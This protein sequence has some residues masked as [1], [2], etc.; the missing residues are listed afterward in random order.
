MTAITEALPQ[1]R[2]FLVSRC[3]IS[4]ESILVLVKRT[5]Y[6][7][8]KNKL[9][10]VACIISCISAEAEM[11]IPQHIYQHT[12]GRQDQRE[13]PCLMATAKALLSLQI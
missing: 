3:I 2:E 4:E 12:G 11:H 10:A 9:V 8:R 6:T 13:V 5:Q 1:L 7:K